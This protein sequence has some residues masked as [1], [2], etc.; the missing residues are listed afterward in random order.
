MAEEAGTFTRATRLLRKTALRPDQA[1]QLIEI[2]DE[3]IKAKV[4]G[5]IGLLTW[6]VGIGIVLILAML[7]AIITLV[8][9]VL[10]K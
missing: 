4:D 2:I 7:G 8:S 10:G 1:N 9:I 3:M 5:K 6:M